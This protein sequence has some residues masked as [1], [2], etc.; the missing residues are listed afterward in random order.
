M[1]P[2]LTKIHQD[3][4]YGSPRVDCQDPTSSI[5]EGTHQN[6]PSTLVLFLS[7][8]TSSRA[9]LLKQPQGANSSPWYANLASSA[10]H[11]HSQPSP[12]TRSPSFHQASP[13]RTSSRERLILQ[14]QQ[15]LLLPLLL[16]P[17]R[18]P[19]SQTKEPIFHISSASPLC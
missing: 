8:V 13:S 4:S 7:H 15:L 9:C 11:P 19:A 5:K 10:A 2:L 16:V 3:S 6:P 18:V 14:E 12:V 17:G 1:V